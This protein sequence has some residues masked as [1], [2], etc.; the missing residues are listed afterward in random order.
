MSKNFV[1]V[2]LFVKV[3]IIEGYL[4]KD[5][6]VKLSFGYVWDLVL[7]GM[8]IEIENNFYLVYE[9]SLDKKNVVVELWK[10]LKDVEVVWFVIDEDCEGEVIFW[11][12]YEVLGLKKKEIKCIMFN[13]IIKGVI[14][15]VIENLRNINILLVDV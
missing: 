3:K 13:E 9:V 4:G 2:E 12:L 11:Y 5:F 1:I 15:C 6:I 7:K 10:L 14:L 8:V